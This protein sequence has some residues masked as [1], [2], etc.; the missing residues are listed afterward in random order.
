M[1]SGQLRKAGGE[2]SLKRRYLA[3]AGLS[4]LLL[5]TAAAKAQDSAT[6]IEFDI[7]AQSLEDALKSYGVAAD[8]QVMFATDIVAGKKAG[9][10]TGEMNET[11]ALG[12]LLD[13]S[14][15]V[16]ETTDTDVVL[17]RAP[18]RQAML[19]Q[20]PTRVSTLQEVERREE[21]E[22]DAG[23]ERDAPRRR[24]EIT[25]TGTLIKGIAPESSPFETF[26]RDQVIETGASSIEDFLRRG[27]PQNF[28]GG[29][30]E[31]APSGLP[32]DS[33]SALNNTYSTGANL[34]GLGSGATLTLLNGRRLAP[35]SSIGEFVDLS[36][37]PISALER[38][39]VL[40]DGASSIYGGDAV[41]GVINFVLRDDFSGSETALRYGTVT[42]GDLDEVRLSQTLGTSWGSGNVLA[43]YEYFNREN[44]VLADRPGIPVPALFGGAPVVDLDLYDLFPEQR[45]HSAVLSLNQDITSD[46]HFS[47]SAMFSDRS[48]DSTTV[49]ALAVSSISTTQVD[50]QALSVASGLEFSLNSD[51]SIALD[52]AFSRLNGEEFGQVIAPVPNTPFMYD[53]ISRLVSGGILINGELFRL[54]GG[55]IKIAVGGQ[56]RGEAFQYA[57]DG[58]APTRDGSRDI[59]AAF[60]ELFFPLLGSEANLPGVERLELN[61][62]GRFDDYSDF[63][64]TFNPKVGI[65]WSPISG[66]NFRGSYSTSFAPPP[67]GRTG[68]VS[69]AGAVA[70]YAFIRGIL[71]IELPDPSLAD[72]N[73]LIVGG[74][75]P[76]LGPEE[77][78]TFTAGLDYSVQTERQSFNAS[79]TYYNVEFDGRLGSTPVPGNL[80]INHAPGL[81]F[82]DPSLFPQGTIVFFPSQAEIDAALASLTALQFGGGLTAV[83]N[84]GFINRVSAIRNLA[85]TETSGIDARFSYSLETDAGKVVL[86]LNGN[87]ITKFVQQAADT[88]PAISTLNTLYNPIDLH[89]RGQL[90]FAGKALSAN[91]FV[92]YRDGYQTD[93]SDTAVD[94]DS[95]TT[96]DLSFAYRIGDQ[97]AQ[98]LSGT[99]LSLFVTNV[100]GANPPET[101]TYG[102]FKLAGYD[103]ANATPLGRIVALEL[104]KRF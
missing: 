4:A 47:T 6:V 72:V 67:L 16:Y 46:I 97:S 74:V 15:L 11:E 42:K 81:A 55:D 70:P 98:W 13:G 3:G 62:S 94:I 44:L 92:N 38:V 57:R 68:Q 32:N 83:E 34:R 73:Y 43:T 20:E 27:L 29:S 7:K 84:I 87:Y 69:R 86:G 25:V 95:W 22:S 24:D 17:V 19:V 33:N 39:D 103:P 10:V 5:M 1:F 104:R 52:G 80:S 85:S 66:L 93:F 77:S 102:S 45:R 21:D 89:L 56:F 37:I 90:G 49:N 79:L 58:N 48:V 71:G 63:G 61:V 40:T 60:A 41:A 75:D 26:S 36:M 12:K 99:T 64:S 51:W 14:G 76:D 8:K 30:S 96:V 82:Q 78:R 2:V 9:P 28:G 88:T 101:P 35:A 53:T 91:V 50:Q 18:Q 59:Y 54:P 65:L 100:I 23:D 31:F